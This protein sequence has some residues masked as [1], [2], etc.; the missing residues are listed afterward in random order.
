MSELDRA[1]MAE[2]EPELYHEVERQE[3]NAAAWA[4]IGDFIVEGRND[5]VVTHDLSGDPIADSSEEFGE[6][7][8]TGEDFDGAQELIDA[9]N[10]ND[11]EEPQCQLCG[12]FGEIGERSGLCYECYIDEEP[13]DGS[14]DDGD[15]HA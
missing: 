5:L 2:L 13:D 7:E 11:A 8:G 6:L 10:E 15:G 4:D 3:H 14:Y 12:N 9:A 1:S